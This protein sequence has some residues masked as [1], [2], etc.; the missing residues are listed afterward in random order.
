MPHEG[1]GQDGE[2]RDTRKAMTLRDFFAAHALSGLVSVPNEATWQ[3]IAEAA[4]SAAD[5]ML[6]ER[7]KP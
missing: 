7:T 1:D 2:S 4:Y 3:H 5:A 6:S